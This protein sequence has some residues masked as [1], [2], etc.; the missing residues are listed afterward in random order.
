M[1]R[2]AR[3]AATWGARTGDVTIHLDSAELTA[4]GAFRA[5]A[6]LASLRDVRAEGETLR[7]RCD[8]EN[9]ALLLGRAAP[10]WAAAL[11][12][13]P[14]SLAAK[15]GITA[16][17]A[18]AVEGVIDDNALAAALAGGRR[19]R[20][21]D[22]ALI[23]ARLDDLAELARVVRRHAAALDRA[24]PLWIVYTKGKSGPLGEAAIRAFLREHGL[25]DLKVASVSP[26]LTALKFARTVRS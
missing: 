3:C 19:T 12:K 1:G 8:G 17:T 23:V 15:L 4:R 5:R 25:I 6:A 14:P 10:R 20:S 2:E 24:V 18:L 16:E 7:F 22:P 9:V 21:G 11:V 13:P 26:A